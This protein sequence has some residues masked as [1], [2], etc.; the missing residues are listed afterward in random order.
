MK[1]IPQASAALVTG[2]SSGFGAAI[3]RSLAKEGRP[4]IGLARRSA[5]LE[6]LREEIGADLFHPVAVDVR[7]ADAVAAALDGLPERFADIGILVN[8]AGLSKGF[9]PVQHAASADW[10][11]MVET[12]INGVLN[13]TRAVLPRMLAAGYGHIVNLGS[14]AASY[15]YLGGNVYGATK[16]FV[17]QLSLNL[18][19]DLDGTGLRV[20][21]VE[22]G[23]AETEFALVRYDGDQDRARALYE[24]LTPLSAEDV[25]NAVVWCLA[26]PVH[27]NVNLIELM[28]TQQLF[29]LG[30]SGAAV[31][32]KVRK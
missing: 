18:R 24:N 19:T 9:G 32:E 1:S 2:A 28:P 23:M 3:A 20:T 17:R 29:G 25:A 10:Q 21:C 11:E 14:I 13:C 22:P 15:P 6:Q 27:V 31:P 5:R 4:V 30:F 8:N 12:N 7:D 26:Q 16:A